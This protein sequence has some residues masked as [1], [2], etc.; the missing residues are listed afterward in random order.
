MAKTDVLSLI[1][2]DYHTISSDY[3]TISWVHTD[4]YDYHTITLASGGFWEIL[5][6]QGVLGGSW[7]LSEVLGGLPVLSTGAESPEELGPILCYLLF[8]CTSWGS[9]R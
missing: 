8:L 1:S 9:G 6:G 3:H 2:Y 4:I 5:R 7:G